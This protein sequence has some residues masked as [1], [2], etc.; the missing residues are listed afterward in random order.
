MDTAHDSSLKQVE[1]AHITNILEQT[2][3]NITKSAEILCIDRST[4]YNKIKR[5]NINKPIDQPV[6]K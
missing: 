3:W 5:H 6:R 4:L 1:R 2:N